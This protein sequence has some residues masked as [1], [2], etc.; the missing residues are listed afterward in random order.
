M[1][2]KT[3]SKIQRLFRA[4]FRLML[5]SSRY[6]DEKIYSYTKKVRVLFIVSDAYGFSC[7]LPVIKELERYGKNKVFIGVTPDKDIPE[8]QVSVDE[9]EV[10]IFHQFYVA[11]KRAQYMKWDLVVNT[12]LN[13]FYPRR[14]CLKGYMHHGPG[15]GILGNKVAI[16]L[17]YDVFFG[18]SKSQKRIFEKVNPTIFKKGR[19]FYSVGFPKSDSVINSRYDP[20]ELLSNLGLGQKKTILITSHWQNNS[21]LRQL[22]YLPFRM[23]AENFSD[24]NVIQTGHPWLWNFK[25]DVKWIEATVRQMKAIEKIYSNARFFP[26]M[27]AEALLPVADVLVADQSS[28]MTTYSIYDKPIVFFDGPDTEFAVKEVGD[29]YRG[30]SHSF[31]DIDDLVAACINAIE[32][33]VEKKEGRAAMRDFFYTNLGKASEVMAENILAIKS[34][35]RP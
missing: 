13:G 31:G 2:L 17:K 9:R 34:R 35:N 22:G 26:H 25:T 5:K 11:N 8:N 20:A 24:F 4:T 7:Q 19:R 12:H 18:L 6:L 1:I 15:F 3:F 16:A 27:Q 33:G 21:T 30:A 29:L 10:D 28:I 23:I 14:Q 32:S